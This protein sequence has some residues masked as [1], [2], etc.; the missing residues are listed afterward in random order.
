[1]N[2]NCLIYMNTP[3]KMVSLVVLDA[4]LQLYVNSDKNVGER[5][6]LF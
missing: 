5:L 6:L 4:R 2:L 3:K 1:M